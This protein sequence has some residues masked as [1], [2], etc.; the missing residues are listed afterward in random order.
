MGIIDKVLSF[1]RQEKWLD[2]E[3]FNLRAGGFIKIERDKVQRR[4]NQDLSQYYYLQN[5]KETLEPQEFED[6][7]VGAK[8][9]EVLKVFS[10]TKGVYLPIKFM[11][12]KVRDLTKEEQ[13]QMDDLKITVQEQQELD[14]ETDKNKKK[15]LQAIVDK[16]IKTDKKVL[17]KKFYGEMYQTYFESKIDTDTLNHLVYKV[18]KNALRLQGGGMDLATKITLLIVFMIVASLVQ[19]WVLYNYFLEPGI[20]FWNTESANVIKAK[21]LNVEQARLETG[22]YEKYEPEQIPV[23]VE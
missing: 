17:L 23:P 4:K 22:Y 21:E 6:I 15:V 14:K 5:A 7:Y 12:N 18:Q 11:F 19:A 13:K 16:R 2:M 8:G 1:I 20:A 3:I 10:P 9:E